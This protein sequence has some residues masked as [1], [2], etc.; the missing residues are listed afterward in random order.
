[1]QKVINSINFSIKKNSLVNDVMLK[2]AGN[3]IKS[4][5]CITK[6]G[7]QEKRWGRGWWG[8]EDTCIKNIFKEL[9]LQSNLLGSS[10]H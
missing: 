10:Q 8:V 5:A 6:S 7:F 4:E 9:Q 1:M 3:N 2:D